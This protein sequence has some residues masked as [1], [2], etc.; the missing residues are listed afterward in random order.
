MKLTGSKIQLALAC[1]YAFR[2]D[3]VTHARPELGEAAALGNAE[4]ELIETEPEAVDEE[5]ATQDAFAAL[6]ARDSRVEDAIIKHGLS[7]AAAEDLCAMHEAWAEWWPTWHGGRV[8]ERETPYAWDVARWTSRRLPSQ[9]QRDYSAAAGCELP[10][11]IDAVHIDKEQRHGVVLDWKTGRLPQPPVAE[12]AQLLTAALCVA[13]AHRLDTMRIALVR[14][15]PGKVWTDEV[16]LDVF[17]LDAW[18][19]RLARVTSDLQSSEP[20]PGRHCVEGHCPALSACEGPRALARRAPEL[21]AALPILVETETQ[22][23]TV[24]STTRAIR[25]YLDA[26]DREAIAWAQQHG[27]TVRLDDRAWS[28]VVKTRRGIDL[29][30]AEGELRKLFG[31]KVDSMI[32]VKRSC[33][34]AEVEKAAAAGAPRGKKEDAK[35]EALVALAATGGLRL[36]TYETWEASREAAKEAPCPTA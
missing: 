6:V 31:A 34:V 5:D 10:L 35:A 23:A 18:A 7:A 20:T 24:L 14:V 15:R 2:P 29:V 16:T 28:R 1:G 21:A 8:F 11:T 19:S 13:H 30:R 25:E 33:S 12:H 27:G 26:L 32:K 17:E 22:A 9:G 4:H 3:A 36:S